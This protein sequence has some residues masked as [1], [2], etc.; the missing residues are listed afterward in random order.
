MN[1][2]TK[3]EIQNAL[4]AGQPV[5]WTTS[6][7]KSETIQLSKPEQ[8]RLFS[9][10][11]TSSVRE[12]K[13][14]SDAFVDGLSQ[15]RSAE[16]D[17]AQQASG[18][19]SQ[20]NLG[21][22]WRLQKLETQGFGGLNIS[23]G[24][25]FTLEFDAESLL[26]QGPNGS[27]KS[28]LVAA[29]LW[30]LTGERPRDQSAEKPEDRA[31]VFDSENRPIGTW[32][33][34]ASYPADQSG[35][36]ANPLVRV[37]L[38]FVDPNGSTAQ[39]ERLLKDGE[40]IPP[41]SPTLQVP[42]IFLE[43]GLLMPARMARLRLEKGPTAL[44]AAVQRLTGL[45]DLI[46]I[47][48][49]ADGLCHKG[50]E[51]LTTHSKDLL[52]QTSL[53]E[54]AIAEVRRALEPTGER[55][56]SFKP[57]DTDDVQGD[58]A[59]LGKKLRTRAGELTKVIADDLTEGLDLTN[60][61]VQLDVAGAISGAREELTLGLASLA[62]WKTLEAL[63]AA[64]VAQTP[65]ALERIASKA[66]DAIIEALAFDDRAKSDSRLQM[67]A[68]AAHWHE[69]NRSGP[70][71]DCPLCD[72]VLADPTLTA[73][74][75]NLR[76]SGQ[77]ATRQL[78]DNLNAIQA[79]FDAAIHQTVAAAI[80]D[81]STFAPRQAV[82][83]G[84]VAR[85]VERERYSS[86][87]ASF[88]KLVSNQLKAAPSEELPL[89][90][91]P[92]RSGS[93]PSQPLR[94]RIS[95]LR[96]ILSLAEWFDCH[97]EDWRSWWGSAAGLRR[98]EEGE[99]SEENSEQVE[100]LNSH[101]ARLS[102]ALGEASPYRIAAEALGR[103]WTA[104]REASRLQKLQ[105]LRE[106]IAEQLSPL[107]TLGALAEAQARMAIGALSTDISDILKRIQLNERLAFKGAQL[108]KKTG[109]LVQA[110]FDES[111]KIDA[112]LVANTSW[113]R[114]LLWAFLLAL[115]AEAVKQHASD[116]L[117]LLVLDDPQATF[118]AEHRHRWV[119][120]IAGLQRSP[121]PTQIIL[122]THDEV[123]LELAKLG[124]IS[125]REAIIVSASSELGH[126]AIFEGAALDRQWTRALA[127]N[128]PSAG[129]DY[130]AAV[131]VHVEGLLR[132]MLRGQDAGVTSV[133]SGFVLGDSREKL[134]QLNAAKY[135]PWDKA[136]FNRLIGQLN[137]GTVAIKHME[138][139]HHA[140][141][142]VLGMGEAT[143]VEQHWRKN[144]APALNRAFLMAREHQLLHGGLNALHAPQPS[145]E[146][147]NGY[148]D[149]IRSL[150]LKIVG[151]AAAFSGSSAADGRMDLTLEAA[152]DTIVLGK[153]WA[154][155]LNAPTLEPVA[156]KG[157][158]L[159][160]RELG[161]PSSRSLV[162]ARVEDRIVARRLEISENH[163][164]VAVLT[165]QSVNP[166][167]IA[168]PLVVKQSTL[169]LHKVV[170]VIFDSARRITQGDDEIS[171]CGGESAIHHITAAIHGLVEVSGQSA[172]PIAL[173]GQLLLVG[174]PLAPADALSQLDGHPVIAG[175]GNENRYFKRLRHMDNDVVVLESLEISGDFPPIVLSHNK[176]ATTDLAQVW[177]VLGVL[178]ERA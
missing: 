74:I 106:D 154:F 37:T 170:G 178:F 125:G 59:A 157:D 70:V 127:E 23:G 140:G 107:K 46:D 87:L 131:R 169:D 159:L 72:E 102:D 96:R 124:G 18:P 177:P 11:L 153:H 119:A 176:N 114:A 78:I 16:D 108:Q 98:E 2:L 109:L 118:D 29:I 164:D 47:G 120:E 171:D 104:G 15:A 27:G 20:A 163:S 133:L 34:V 86:F 12:P 139:S 113:L 76:S 55:V 173:D 7:N 9:Y 130:I 110:G 10:L 88:T 146:L 73:E 60:A 123:F 134:R 166:Q 71:A 174:A 32:P 48:L 63:S 144:L 161:A 156:R 95:A 172:E 41:Q 122:A 81:A 8:R 36:S 58:L 94:G 152:G 50:R 128:T 167:Q 80:P 160:V 165:A 1:R 149:K 84:L 141:R 45:D 62:P 22:P 85:F 42:D 52:H 26:L 17:P 137:A 135:A 91:S 99:H 68:L 143:D 6:T 40:I 24:P 66:E 3:T 28:S 92:E 82:V 57:K 43:T 75:E 4:L 100:S 105:G 162:V 121:I 19:G 21:G 33:P 117:A 31:A 13:G 101:L 93:D 83:D 35:L 168:P 126:A 150:R 158:V 175:D 61:K 56:E 39:V 112:T 49:L 30:A 65:S 129:Q 44:T 77:A 14:L 69:A 67:K 51:Y 116:P 142:T 79:E 54:T 90:S 136:E 151:R 25:P 145:C 38:T 138:L 111:F 148:T 103:A 147:P 5:S 132:L 64:V 53:F 97:S 115:R 89:E 155:R